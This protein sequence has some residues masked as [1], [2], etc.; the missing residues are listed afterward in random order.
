MA[1][2]YSNRNVFCACVRLEMQPGHGSYSVWDADPSAW[3]KSYDLMSNNRISIKKI[4]S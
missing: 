2:S 4:V 1:V 3:Q